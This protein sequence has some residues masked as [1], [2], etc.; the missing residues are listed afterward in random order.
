MC[1]WECGENG[2]CG[3]PWE[4]QEC[5]ESGEVVMTE[6]E[7]WLF[8]SLSCWQ[9]REMHRTPVH[10]GRLGRGGTVGESLSTEE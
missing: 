3:E 8:R 7:R 6:E 4:S 9:W 10:A 2:E 1:G 5:W